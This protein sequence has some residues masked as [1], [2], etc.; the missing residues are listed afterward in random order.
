[1]FFCGRTGLQKVLAAY[2]IYLNAA[3]LRQFTEGMN[4]QLIRNF[5]QFVMYEIRLT[6]DQR[7]ECHMTRLQLGKTDAERREDARR[8]FVR[9]AL[10]QLVLV[11]VFGLYA[12]GKLAS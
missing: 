10:F 8:G 3:T 7:I 1:M 4:M 5:F 2:M 12:I 6:Q 9:K 11:L